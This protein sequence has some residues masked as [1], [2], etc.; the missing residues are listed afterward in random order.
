L[1]A[2]GEVTAQQIRRHVLLQERVFLGAAT[3]NP[4]LVDFF[5]RARESEE[6][7]ERLRAI[8]SRREVVPGVVICQVCGRGGPEDDELMAFPHE[9]EVEALR[10][11][12]RYD[13]EDRWMC[14]ECLGG[15]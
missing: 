9:L 11:G 15:M 10:A 5:W 13:E 6:Y 2:V 7:Q 12:W 1:V 3:A 14:R 4:D 8:S